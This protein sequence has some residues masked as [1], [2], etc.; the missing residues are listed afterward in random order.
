MQL[1][2]TEGFMSSR[3]DISSTNIHLLTMDRT[4][5]EH[6][7]EYFQR[8]TVSGVRWSMAQLM[9]ACHTLLFS[10]TL[11]QRT[12]RRIL[13]CIVN[14]N[15][16]S[17]FTPILQKT[18]ANSERLAQAL[19]SPSMD[20]TR[21]A[22]LTIATLKELCLLIKARLS[23]LVQ[24]LEPKYARHILLSIHG[25]TVDM[26]EAWEILSPLL[27]GES[28]PQRTPSHAMQ[29]YF[30]LIR[31]SPM[32]QATSSTPTSNISNSSSHKA[33]NLS[34]LPSS[35][36]SIR[37]R[38]QS[39]QMTSP[40]MSPLTSPNTEDST[41]LF[42]HL[43]LAVMG[44]VSVVE[45]LNQSIEETLAMDI[46]S[47]LAKKL[48]DLARIGQQAAELTLR[49]DKALENMTTK[50]E[51]PSSATRKESS[52]RFWEDANGYLKAI[53]LV[54]SSVRA[55]STEEEF[56]WPKAVKQGCLHVTRVTAEVAK[57]WNNDSVFAE[58]GYYLGGDDKQ[59]HPIQRSASSSDQ[60]LLPAQLSSS[61]SFIASDIP[62]N[63]KNS[64]T[65]SPQ[66]SDP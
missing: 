13:T 50:D 64:Q 20:L 48:N 4:P 2:P 18:K 26:K 28:T 27:S 36:P 19:E 15:L 33:S 38:S 62:M 5:L 32:L 29:S 34:P 12:L 65:S 39:E 40:I 63:R 25:A 47:T 49:L 58:D 61:P 54:M 22:A 66:K 59:H 37:G 23:T 17:A 14:D 42:N 57:L 30:P 60:N 46:S 9:E 43:K 44:S 52:R 10:A 41:S 21:Q 35:L 7:A 1:T 45:L 6:D 51:Q 3:A 11:V 31:P 55:V 8:T 24:V 53:V 16:T 56:A